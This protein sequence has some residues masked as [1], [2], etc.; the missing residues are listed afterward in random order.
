MRRLAA[1]SLCL[2]ALACNQPTTTSA[3]S[4]PGPNSL[5]VAGRTLLVASTANDELRALDLSQD[6]RSFVR[7]P[8]P[9]FPLSIPTAPFPR[10]VAAYA[11]A[12]GTTLPFAFALSTAGG[13]VNV[14]STATLATLGAVVVPDVSM[15][16]AVTRPEDGQDE[17]LVLAVSQGEN[18]SLWTSRFKSAIQSDPTLLSTDAN[19]QPS[20]AVLLGTS[21]PQVVA[22]SPADPDIVAVGDRLTGPDGLGR[23]GGLAV[24]NL[25]TG[26]VVR[27]DVGGPVM[28]LSF[29]LAGGRLFGL[30]DAEGCGSERPCNG[31]FRVDMTDP[32]APK[33]S[34]GVDVPSTGRGLAV[35]GAIVVTMPAGDSVTVDPLV[36]ASATDGA[37]YAFDGSRMVPVSNAVTEARSRVLAFKRTLPDG[38]VEADPRAIADGPTVFDSS[39]GALV[40]WLDPTAER[41]ETVTFTWEGLLMSG[42]DGSVAGT[43]LLAPSYDFG[44]LG[45]QPGDQ[46]VFG[47]GSVGSCQRDGDGEVKATVVAVSPGR[48]ELSGATTACV[49]TEAVLFGVRAPGVYAVFGT[50]S[51]FAGRAEPGTT[52]GGAGMS[53]AVPASPLP[54]RGTKYSVWLASSSGVLA[55]KKVVDGV[56]ETDPKLIQ[57]GPLLYDAAGTGLLAVFDS[58]VVCNETLTL[59]WEGALARGRAGRLEGSA[60]V[61]AAF[62]FKAQGVLNGDLVL[63][64]KESQGTCALD[65]DG[66]VKGRVVKASAGR[67]EV[68]G[69]PQGCLPTTGLVYAVRA[70]QAYVAIGSRSGQHGRVAPG[71]RFSGAGISFDVWADPVPARD[72]QYAVSL[73]SAVAHF[74]VPLGASVMLPGAVAY[75]PVRMLFYAAYPGGNAIVE[76]KPTEMRAGDSTLGVVAYH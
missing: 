29:D 9:L 16:I 27:L 64:A 33:L 38:T 68:D 2:S 46:V 58:T 39:T 51:G 10:A 74:S 71:K 45:V 34:G 3:V 37:L 43:A 59:T 76:L 32:A 13:Q 57:G 28:A 65:G 31:M 5:G 7:A 23:T 44:S 17:R 21:T 54:A 61:D 35:G 70:P 40:A 72:T 66:E 12:D 53:L 14:V 75:D 67:L 63:V 26:T 55:F 6:P 11:A 18:G 8:N 1:L 50:L 36:V 49:S 73:V 52:F 60:L 22:A 24:C 41:N 48:L 47:E 19:V 56:Q 25:R 42:T 4:I 15:A 30:L 20:M 69:L 62:D